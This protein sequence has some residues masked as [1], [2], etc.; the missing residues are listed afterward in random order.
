MYLVLL[1]VV[2][3]AIC[4]LSSVRVRVYTSLAWVILSMLWPQ[5]LN[6]NLTHIII[7]ASRIFDDLV[8]HSNCKMHGVDIPPYSWS[9]LWDILLLVSIVVQM[10][11]SRSLYSCCIS[12]LV[13]L[14]LYWYD[15]LQIKIDSII[16]LWL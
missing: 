10:F 15:R 11:P 9:N 7:T 12:S 1:Y 8:L 5:G 4:L 14:L 6:A 3:F 2:G 16:L 13:Q